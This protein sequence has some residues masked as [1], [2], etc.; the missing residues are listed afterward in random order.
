MHIKNALAASVSVIALLG[1]TFA[2]VA[3][4]GRRL[5][6]LPPGLRVYTT[7]DVVGV[8]LASALAGAYTVAL[9][10]ADGVGMGPGPRAVLVTRI[11]TDT[12][13]S[14]RPE[15]IIGRV[16]SQDMATTAVWPS[17][18]PVPDSS[19]HAVIP[20]GSGLDDT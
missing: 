13:S 3:S 20:T 11:R 16:A 4:E 18:V 19:R 2:E 10:L 9:G 14:R 5:F 7:T 1:S 8:E 15:P 6:T 12:P 17:G